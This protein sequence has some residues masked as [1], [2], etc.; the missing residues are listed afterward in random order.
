MQRFYLPHKGFLFILFFA[1]LFSFEKSY[2]QCTACSAYTVNVN[3]SSATDTAWT[4]THTRSGNCC[5]GTNCIR[6]NVTLNPASDLLSFDVTNPSPSGSAYYQIECGP[7]VPIGTPACIVGL[8]NICIVYCKPGGDSPIYHITATRTVHGSPD[9]TVRVGC[10]GTMSVTGLQ[11]SS[12]VWTSIYPGV[13]GQYNSLLS[14]TSA[15]A[16]TNF[17]PT[18]TVPTY[19]DYMVSGNPNTSCPG[20]SRDTIRMYVV[21]TMS[22]TISPANPVLCSAGPG[23]VTLTANPTGGAPPYTYSWSPGGQT[24][25]SISVSSPGTYTVSVLD[26][27]NSCPAITQTITVTSVTTPSPPTASSNSPVCTGSPINLTA[28]LI[29]G[30]TYSWTGPNGF[31]SALQNPTIASAAAAN[32]GTYTVTATVSGC[33]SSTSTTTV[34]V[35]PVPSP[36]TASSNSPICAG[37]TLNLTASLVAGAT[38]SWTG[39]NSFSSS[40]QNPSIAGATV[41]ATGTYSVNVTVAGCTSTNATTAVTVNP[42][43]APPTASSNSPICAG[44]T[45]NLTSSLVAGATYSWTGPNS[46]SSSSQNPSIGSAT[47]AATGTYSV[48]VTVGGCTSTNATTVVTVNP[49]PAPP[50]ASSNSPICAGSTLNLTSSLVAGATYSWTGPNSFSSSSQNPSIA[51]ATVAATGT[52]MYEHK[53]NNCCNCKSCSISANCIK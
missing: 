27:T 52:W 36:P 15:C 2:G 48:N 46:F 32:A 53:C 6:F 31:S 16:S 21:P 3:L 19:I 45:L 9:D 37:S 20:T 11:T 39:P 30:A 1:V 8:T 5:T 25:Q 47:T 49:I 17:T 22:V 35:N 26:Q 41:A 34:V 29:A 23:S 38:Y 24:T 50:T 44:S 42:T 33:T 40:S 28:S 10:T 4:Y 12:I 43:P 18:S 7:Q 51:G 13:T 14:C